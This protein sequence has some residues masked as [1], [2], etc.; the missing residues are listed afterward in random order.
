MA[1]GDDPDRD[2]PEGQ[3]EDRSPK[4]PR[5]LIR[6][7]RD[8]FERFDE[9]EEIREL[10]DEFVGEVRNRFVDR[11]RAAD[12]DRPRDDHPRCGTGEGTT[13]AVEWVDNPAPESSFGFLGDVYEVEASKGITSAELRLPVDYD[14]VGE[15]ELDPSTLSL[16]RWDEEDE[17]Y[18][19]VSG[20]R[21]D[22]G[23]QAVVGEISTPGRYTVIGRSTNP[24]IQA[25]L[26][27]FR[28]ASGLSR[29]GELGDIIRDDICKVILCRQDE[30]RELIRDEDIPGGEAI[31]GFPAG[32]ENPCE[33][34]FG[35]GN[36]H[37][38][39]IPD[40][41]I[42]PPRRD[43]GVGDG[44]PICD[45]TPVFVL[46]DWLGEHPTIAGSIVWHKPSGGGG[47]PHPY[48]N[49]STE[50]KNQLAEVYNTIRAGSCPGLSDAPTVDLNLRSD[51]R[52]FASMLTRDQ[53]WDAYLA[54][55][56]QSL[57]AEING[58]V[59]WTLSDYGPPELRW[60]FNSETLFEYLSGPGKYG[61]LQQHHV[62]VSHG[63][64]TP[65]DP[66]RTFSFLRSQGIL[67]GTRKETIVRLI[68][69]CR[70]H[71]AHFL[72]GYT[73]E[74]LDD[75]WQYSGWPPVERIIQGTD[76]Q[77]ESG[78]DQGFHHWTGGCWGTTAFLQFV[79]RTANVPVEPVEKGCHMLPHFLHE[80]L[81]LSH[82]DD[83]YNQMMDASPPIPAEEILI[84]EATFQSWFG[85]GVSPATYCGN[86][87]RRVDELMVEY[88]PNELLR[89]H[90]EDQDNGR[91][92]ASSHV[93]D[94]LDDT[95]TLAELQ[96]ENLWTRM[97][98]KIAS[99]GGCD[100]IP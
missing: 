96:S 1:E 100:Q 19:R 8:E 31:P 49:W 20:S 64:A 23:E 91:T 4:Q 77:D 35:V 60:L 16:F 33:R 2:E 28:Q 32:L 56:A 65:G 97:N 78:P 38:G 98:N 68:D 93:L 26:G 50:E 55:V 59:P 75:H 34:C 5:D 63:A 44:I 76:H 18:R 61:I 57:A 52:L 62:L 36:G 27:L 74:N 29:R 24:W 51:G 48:P 3:S 81:A 54:H 72:Y 70:H 83:P 84:D 67:A 80:G 79:L 21:M 43:G 86:I 99:M 42:P 95:Y 10:V 88:L 7:M 25:T 6:E 87:G 66:C 40:N 53:A 12:S 82:G 22:F 14:Q 17:R 41:E 45:P 15:R 9:P 13:F 90:C 30:F 92:P 94:L 71:L 37:P 47:T 85:S 73:P 89:T 11:P 69:W 46:D 58:W 39:R